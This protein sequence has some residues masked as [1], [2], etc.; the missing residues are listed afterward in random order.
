MAISL[1]AKNKIYDLIDK[2]VDKY[3]AKALKNLIT[4]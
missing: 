4:G 1:K 3:I 2:L